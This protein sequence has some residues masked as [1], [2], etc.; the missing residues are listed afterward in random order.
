MVHAQKPDFVFRRK[1]RVHLNLQGAS[2]Q[3]TTGSRCVRISGSNAGYTMFRGSVKSTGYTLSSPVSPSLP[4]TCDT[5][6]HHIS[7]GLC[8]VLLLCSCMCCLRSLN[9]S[10]H[11]QSLFILCL[12]DYIQDMTKV[13]SL[14]TDCRDCPR[15]WTLGMASWKRKAK[16]WIGGN[17]SKT[18]SRYLLNK[19]VSNSQTYDLYSGDTQFEPWTNIAYPEVYLGIPQSLQANACIL[20]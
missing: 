5:V 10:T 19:S 2:V 16:K 11:S 3:S 14:L 1:G 17:H 20:F 12:F 6:C 4:V 18:A 9:N 8:R 7:T 15:L 13:E